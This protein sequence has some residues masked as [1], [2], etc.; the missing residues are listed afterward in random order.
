MNAAAAVSAIKKLT[1]RFSIES[2]MTFGGE[3]LL[4]ADAVCKIHAAARDCGIQERQLIT[5]GFFSKDEQKID[6]VAKALCESGV[7]DILLSIDVFHQEFIPLEPVMWFAEALLR[8]KAPRLR[9]QPAW[10]VNEKAE[11]LYNTQTRRLLKLFADKGI[12]ANDGNDIFPSGN[13]LKHLGEYFAPPGEVDLSV[14]C[15][16][17]PYTERLDEVSSFSINPNGDVC[18]CSVIIGNIHTND[19]LDI[20]DNYD[21]YANPAWNAI[22]IG[23]VSELLR[24][25]EKQGITTDISD[26]RS[27]CGVCRKLMTAI[28]G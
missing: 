8:C 22:I 27:A 18:L 25:T 2:V 19:V 7:N 10:V 6:E 5:N 26:C 16:A 24:Y 14:P 9:V 21:P 20:V 28:K 23:G 13:A 1:E 12:A 15:G 4:F 17:M 3:P 11:N